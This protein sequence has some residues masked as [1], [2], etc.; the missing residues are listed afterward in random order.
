MSDILTHTWRI[1]DDAVANAVGG[2]TVI[3]HL[4]N[5]N[6]YGLDTIGTVLWDGLKAGKLPSEVCDAILAEY[7]AERSVVENDLAQ[8][9]EELRA[10]ELVEAA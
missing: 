4:G 7:D 1:S 3:L 2:E 8:F 9:L 5:G 10:N 6:Y